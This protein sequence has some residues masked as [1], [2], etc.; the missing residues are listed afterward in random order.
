MFEDEAIKR[1]T[2]AA[3]APSI[4]TAA[5]WLRHVCV[6]VLLHA[7]YCLSIAVKAKDKMYRMAEQSEIHADLLVL[8]QK[9][10]T[11]QES[12]LEKSWSRYGAGVV[13]PSVDL[14]TLSNSR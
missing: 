7:F 5:R 8:C 14:F 10:Q 1:P 11:F 3:I 12:T 13:L 9:F 2:E 4:L 6:R